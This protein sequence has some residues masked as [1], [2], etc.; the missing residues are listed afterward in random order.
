V[1]GWLAALATG[2]LPSSLHR[3]LAAYA[4]YW[5]HVWAFASVVG[6]PFPGFTGKQGSFPVDVLVDPPARQHRLGV[7][8]RLVLAVPALLL[9]GALVSGVAIVALLGWFAALFTGRMPRGL[10]ELG[11]VTIR[12]ETQTAAYLLLLTSRYPYAAPAVTQPPAPLPAAET[13]AA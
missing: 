2:R 5:A 6:G 7:L 12:Y 11:A 8:G 4:R 10:L 3:F 1:A 13:V 9:A